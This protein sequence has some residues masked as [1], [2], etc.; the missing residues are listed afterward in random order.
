MLHLETKMSAKLSLAVIKGV[1]RR[2]LGTGR[3]IRFTF[4]PPAC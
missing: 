4:D 2:R 1:P 3:G